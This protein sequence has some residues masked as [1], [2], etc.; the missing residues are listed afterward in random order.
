[1]FIIYQRSKP[2]DL[3]KPINPFI[4]SRGASKATELLNDSA[5]LVTFNENSVPSDEIVLAT[6]KIYFQITKN[7]QI[8]STFDNT[9]LFWKETCNYFNSYPTKKAGIIL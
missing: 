9:S 5:Y 2:E 8:T 3:H 6:Y 4:V 7:E 1:M